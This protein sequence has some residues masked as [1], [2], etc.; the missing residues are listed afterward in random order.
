MQGISEQPGR[1][2][3]RSVLRCSVQCVRHRWLPL[4]AGVDAAPTA[5]L[6]T[7]VGTPAA[8]A[9]RTDGGTRC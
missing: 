7:Y 5:L 1:V 3:Y 8:A 2:D 9:F 4:R 6:T